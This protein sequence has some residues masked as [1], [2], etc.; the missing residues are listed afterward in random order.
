MG[1]S[2]QISSI[3]DSCLPS[4]ILSLN[5]QTHQ[6]RVDRPYDTVVN[7]G[8]R[9]DFKGPDLLSTEVNKNFCTDSAEITSDT[10]I[11]LNV[12]IHSIYTCRWKKIQ[13]SQSASFLP[14][15]KAV[16]SVFSLH[17]ILEVCLADLRGAQD[18]TE[19]AASKAQPVWKP[20]QHHQSLT[21][22]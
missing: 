8:Y 20:T 14:K 4:K 1:N 5:S 11:N 17:S 2:S 16:P 3:Q 15:K 6:A 18:V 21:E 7:T 10:S 12:K 9:I 22:T 13:P 19:G